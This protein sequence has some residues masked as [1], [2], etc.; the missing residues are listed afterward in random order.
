LRCSIGRDLGFKQRRVQEVSESLTPYQTLLGKSARL[1]V[2]RF[3]PP[4]AFLAISEDEDVPGAPVLLLPGF[5]IPEGTTTGEQLDVFVY[6]DSEDRPIATLDVPKIELG[7]IAFLTVKEVLPIGAFVDW[8][9]P[10]DLLVPFAEQTRDLRVGDRH[11]F[12]L[13]IDASGRLAATMRVSERLKAKGVFEL[14]EWVSGETWRK[15]DAI[16]VFVILER[17]YVGLLPASE[18]HALRRGET[19]EFRIARIHEDG[20][21]ELSQ[22]A[23]AHDEIETDAEHIVEVLAASP[24]LHLGDKSAPDE[25]RRAFGISKKAFKRSVGKLLREG[26]IQ[27][28]DDGSLRLVTVVSTP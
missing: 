15:D 27:I 5:E 17:K 12:A 7:Q 10:K 18:P 8:G 2:R 13:F 25:I 20:R 4:G 11:P 19:A 28:L 24:N 26:R 14:G 21:V 6:L 3:G 16:G 22:R 23:L 1:A 9:L